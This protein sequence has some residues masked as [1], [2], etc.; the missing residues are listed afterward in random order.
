MNIA[1]IEE[2]EVRGVYT[3]AGQVGGGFGAS[4]GNNQAQIAALLVPRAERRRSS[5]EIAAAWRPLMLDAIPAA[6][7][8]IVR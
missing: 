3:V 7:P 2:A 4:S 1:Q 5:A 8:A 6:P